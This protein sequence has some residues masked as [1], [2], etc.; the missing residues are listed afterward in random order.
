M[1]RMIEESALARGHEVVLK[2][3]IDNRDTLKPQ[4]LSIADVAIDF[5]APDSAI[6]NIQFCM[7][8]GVPVVVGTTGWYEKLEKVKEIVS[9]NNGGLLYASNFSL[10]VNI[11]FGLNKILAA[12]MNN[13][14]GYNVEVEEIHHTK[15]LDSPSGT[16]ITLAE[17]I[18]NSIKRK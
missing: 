7:E 2:I 8:A 9:M 5:T 12:W 10:G 14:P 6:A 15:K 1:G 18:L 4:D 17:G 3:D 16:A 11:L 13:Y